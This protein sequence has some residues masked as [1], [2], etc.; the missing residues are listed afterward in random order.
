MKRPL[1]SVIIPFYKNNQLLMNAI[2]SVINQKFKNFE[3]IIIN[4]NNIEKNINFLKKI[5]KISKKIK[6][7]YNKKN[8]GAGLSRNKGIKLSKGK[9][10][11]FL[12]SDDEWMKNKLS[13][14]INIMKK[15]N[16]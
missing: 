5:K 10:I 8:L 6:I 12:D 13:E 4:D 15:K 11:A 9:Y 14:Q 7:I 16:I 3:I 1:V 2:N